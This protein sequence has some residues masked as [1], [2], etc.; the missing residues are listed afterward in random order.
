VAYFI[1]GISGKCICR[2]KAVNKEGG[3][4]PYIFL[5][6]IPHAGINDRRELIPMPV[7]N[8]PLTLLQKIKKEQKIFAVKIFAQN[9]LK[10]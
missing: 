3:V 6:W 9:D 8:R 1:Y 10:S 4:T 5:C 2:R 7:K